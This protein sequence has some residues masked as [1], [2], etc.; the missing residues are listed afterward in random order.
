MKITSRVFGGPFPVFVLLIIL[1]LTWIPRLRGPIDLRWDAALYYTLGTSLAEGHGYRMMNEPGHIEATVWPPLLPAF[2]AA[3][4]RI[5]HTTDPVVVGAWLR[6]S[7]FLIWLAYLAAAY[8]LFRIHLGIGLAMFAT[9]VC[10][11]DLSAVWLS[12]RC[13]ADLPFALLVT[14]FFIVASR[15]ATRANTLGA[16]LLAALAFLA[17]S[18]G[19]ALFVGWIAEALARRR[20]Q[21]AA[22]RVALALVPVLAWQGFIAHVEAEPSYAHPPYAYARADYALYNVSYERN[23]RLRDPNA[24]ELGK[25]TPGDLVRRVARNVIRIPMSVGGGVS[26]VERDWVTMMEQI[27]Q[28]PVARRL[29]P[30]RAIPLGLFA[31]GAL[32]IAGAAML[33]TRGHVLLA[34]AATMYLLHLCLLPATDQWPRYLVG[35]APV[36]V[37]AFVFALS[38]LRWTWAKTAIV[39]FVLITQT[40]TLGWWFTHEFRP[41]VHENWYG[42]RVVYRLFSYD[43]AFDAFDAGL[44]W[45]QRTGQTDQV[46]VSSM[47]PW[48]YVRTGMHAV[49][50]PLERRL[51]VVGPLLDT[52][53]A[54]YVIV[55]TCGL[56]FTR[57]YTLPFVSA[58]RD[59]WRLSY[60]APQGG[61]EIYERRPPVP[62]VALAATRRRGLN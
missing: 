16:W 53:P 27:K 46:V 34:V 30:W 7:F 42:H 43:A 33:V 24:P 17:R 23:M 4:Q 50:P 40:C 19:L 6:G 48:V 41:V 8:A 55:D 52:V 35:I 62:G 5:L 60:T 25:A 32:T 29:V 58:A 2:V 14:L 11:L 15:P 37:L 28:V 44:E 36:L 10:G 57:K 54:T 38:R 45:L 20:F 61:L 12:D 3:H 31:L 22:L 47:A 21:V 1:S 18:V 39:C 13:Y 59:Q 49:L 26:A 9:A 56:S 51:D